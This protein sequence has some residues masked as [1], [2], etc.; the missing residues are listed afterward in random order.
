MKLNE[1]IEQLNALKEEDKSLGECEIY[2]YDRWDNLYGSINGAKLRKDGH[3][4]M[5]TY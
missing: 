5:L 3:G 4:V 2:Y 1:L